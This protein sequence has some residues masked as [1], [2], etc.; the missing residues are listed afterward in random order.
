[1]LSHI[2]ENSNTYEKAYSTI[3]SVLSGHG[4]DIDKDIVV[5]FAHQHK[6]GNNFLLGED[7]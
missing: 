1:M 3:A 5:R 7:K 6:I 4:V 2:S